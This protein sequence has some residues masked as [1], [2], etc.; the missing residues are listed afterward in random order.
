MVGLSSSE[1]PMPVPATESLAALTSLLPADERA[2]WLAEC[3][4]RELTAL[5]YDWHFWARPAQLAPPGQWHIWLQLGGRGGGKTRAGAEWV[6]AQVECGTCRRIA[7]VAETASDARDVMVE[8]TSGILA[9]SP[10]AFRPLYEPSK[11][12]LTWPNGAMATTYS[13]D[14]PEQ[15]RGPQHDG[16]WA[17]EI[18]KWRRPETWD[19]LMLG[20][21]LG[22]DPRC[23]ATTTPKPV[24]LVRTLLAQ[25]GGTTVI[26]RSTTYENAD[27]LAPVF[28]EQIIRRYEGTRLGRQELQGEYLED[29]PGALWQRSQLD[30]DRV[31]VAPEHLQRVVVAIDPAVTSGEDSDETGIVVVGRDQHERGYVLADYSLR[32]T[33]L[34]WAR[35]AVW[36]YHEHRADGIVAEVNNGGD[37]V[38]TVLRTVDQV[39]PLTTVH[40]SRGKRT[41]AEPIASLYEQ[42]RVHHVGTLADLED[43]LCLFA[44]DLDAD[45]ADDRVDALCWGLHDVMGFLLQGRLVQPE[46]VPIIDR[47][48]MRQAVN[49]ARERAELGKAARR[50]VRWDEARAAGVLP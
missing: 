46:E 29:L 16:A 20:L 9:V 17:D 33:P 1:T 24:R 5:E 27:N 14:D 22:D 6:R 23:V 4:D 21:R 15:L 18:A 30:A 44:P 50:K 8:G 11:R 42:H 38:E 34:E 26:T 36:A 19:N 31:T 49:H 10:P 45:G 35:R 41:R 39:V 47:T 7:L 40:A 48:L 25:A 37:L 3:S 12:R 32:G 28:L 13:A 2:A 43:Q